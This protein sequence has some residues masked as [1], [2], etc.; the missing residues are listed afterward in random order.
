MLR[1]NNLNDF[2]IDLANAIRKK[3]KTTCQYYANDFDNIIKDIEVGVENIYGK[4]I[5]LTVA[6]EEKINKGDFVR[7]TSDNKVASII[8]AEDINDIVGI[9]VSE[10]SVTSGQQIKICI[11]TMKEVTN[12]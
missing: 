8:Y 9:S 1:V 6:D 11:P 4:E 3:T 7:I 5:T 12:G 2:L 10:G